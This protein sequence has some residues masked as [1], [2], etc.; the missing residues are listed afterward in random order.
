MHRLNYAQIVL[1]PGIEDAEKITD[2]TL[3]SLLNGIFKII[4]E[5]LAKRL[6]PKLVEL[7]DIS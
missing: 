2:F 4:N 7:V 3:I 5:V 6:R 1:I